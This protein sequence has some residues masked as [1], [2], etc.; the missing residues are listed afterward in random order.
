MSSISRLFY[1]TY[2]TA[3]ATPTASIRS[4][5]NELFKE[6][7]LKRVVEKFKQFSNSDR[8]RDKTGIYDSTVRRLA[9]AKRFK[10]IEEILEYQKQFKHDFSKEGFPVRLITLYGKSRMFDHAQKVFDEM[11]ENN[12]GRTVNSMNA[13]LAAAVKS[14]KFDQMEELFN[15]LP[16]KYNIR[17]D[18]VSYNTVIKGLCEMG[19]L[20]QS[21]SMI[22]EMEKSGLKPDLITFNTILYSLY[23][24]NRFDDGEKIWSQMLERKLVPNIRTYNARLVGL[25]NEKRVQEATELVGVL[26]NKNLKADVFSYGTL[27]KAYGMEGNLEEVKRW[28]E[29]MIENKCDPD[30]LVFWS[31]I[32]S[33]SEKGDF[34]WAYEVCK[35]IFKWNCNV[36][37]QILQKVVDGLVKESKIEEAK[38]VVHLGQSRRYTKL[39]LPTDA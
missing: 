8:F 24:N 18:V 31:V 11:T 7:N 38:Q 2:C 33:A 10:S 4:L 15:E 37:V 19:S 3:T 23:S 30:K 1:R 32:S 27:I 25:V 9:S 16:V 26:E 17:P 34:D 28:Y 35:D 22:C 36:D 6:R 5:S 14:R 21:I 29:K 12:C 20:D 13:L 39:K